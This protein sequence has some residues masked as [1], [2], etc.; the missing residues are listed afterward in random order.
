MRLLSASMVCPFILYYERCR[1]RVDKQTRTVNTCQQLHKAAP[2]PVVLCKRK[3]VSLTNEICTGGET[4][5]EEPT[6]PAHSE[7][8]FAFKLQALTK[9]STPSAGLS[10]E[11]EDIVVSLTLVVSFVRIFRNSPINLL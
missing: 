6:R 8:P 2:E 4:F 9:A 1:P 11:H 3:L 7:V 5:A 10:L